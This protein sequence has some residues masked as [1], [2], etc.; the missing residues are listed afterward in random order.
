MQN[1]VARC[2]FRLWKNQG[3]P[4]CRQACRDLNRLASSFVE[5][6]TLD[7]EDLSLNTRWDKTWQVN[8]KL[9]THGLG[10]GDQ[11]V[12]LFAWHICLFSQHSQLDATHTYATPKGVTKRCRLPWLTNSILVYERAQTPGGGGGVG[13]VQQRWASTLAYR[14]NV[15]HRSNIQP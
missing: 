13:G 11:D 3:A 4:S 9:K 2:S 5:R 15:R 6:L 12:I 14:L 1:I 10:T 8:L 7:H